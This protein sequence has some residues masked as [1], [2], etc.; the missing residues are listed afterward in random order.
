[1]NFFSISDMTQI[2]F[3]SIRL[4]MSEIFFSVFSSI[5]RRKIVFFAVFLSVIF[6][7]ISFSDSSLKHRQGISS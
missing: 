1:M 4:S 5:S 7:S 3:N 2:P 6:Y